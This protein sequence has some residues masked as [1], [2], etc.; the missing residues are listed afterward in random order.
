[1]KATWTLFTVP[2]IFLFISSC[3]QSQNNAS[4]KQITEMIN[5]F[6]KAHSIVM[7][8]N[9]MDSSDIQN[10][11]LDSIQEKYCTLKLKNK[12]KKY[13]EDGFDYVTDEFDIQP[14][15]LKTLTI[16]KDS[17]NHD[18]YI[19]SYIT[20]QPDANGKLIE[21]EVALKVSVVNKK[22]AYKIN[23]VNAIELEY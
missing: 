14:E 8:I 21:K 17:K 5:E 12:A 6:Y 16:K 23:D 10:I 7:S 13:W 15:S 20:S 4:D 9:S 18:S 11:K 2:V 3:M 22:G 1:M 19:V